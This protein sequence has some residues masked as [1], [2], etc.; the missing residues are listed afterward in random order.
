MNL[1]ELKKS[2]FESNNE[3]KKEYDNLE[4]EYNIIRQLIQ[5]RIANNMS[6]KELARLIGTKQSNISRIENGKTLPSLTMLNKI[7][8]ALNK[9][10]NVKI[11]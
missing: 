5:I 1:N 8:V 9:E 6:Q 2:I 4:L 3:V 7:A 11:L 10:I